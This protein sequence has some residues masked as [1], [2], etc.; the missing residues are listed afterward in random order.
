[1][2]SIRTC[3][4]SPEFPALVDG[5][6][7]RLS[8]LAGDASL[9]MDGDA[10]RRL[11]LLIN[12]AAEAAQNSSSPLS[13]SWVTLN[14]DESGAP[15]IYFHAYPHVLEFDAY[16]GDGRLGGTLCRRRGAGQQRAARAALGGGGS[17]RRAALRAVDLRRG[18]QTRAAAALERDDARVLDVQVLQLRGDVLLVLVEQQS[19]CLF[20]TS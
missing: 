14:I 15:A 10:R 16:S 2:K 7:R 20:Q 1:M 9:E 5:A 19:I 13:S 18:G 3:C 8:L 4:L 6:R 12:A 17:E 11:S